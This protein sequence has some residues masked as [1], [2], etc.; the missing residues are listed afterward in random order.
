[1]QSL[2]IRDAVTSLLF[3]SE[4]WQHL[5]SKYWV[6]TFATCVTGVPPIAAHHLLVLSNWRRLCE[7]GPIGLGNIVLLNQICGGIDEA[8]FFLATVGMGFAGVVLV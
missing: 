7:T 2:F 1:V 5:F 8:H 3:T 6:H 4:Q